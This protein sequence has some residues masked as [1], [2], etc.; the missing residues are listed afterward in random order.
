MRE[1]SGVKR[2]AWMDRARFFAILMVVLCH[3]VEFGYAFDPWFFRNYFDLSTW[4]ERFLF[5]TMGRLGVPLLLF[6][7]G[8]LM[9]NRDYTTDD[10]IRAFYKKNYLRIFICVECWIVL[11]GFYLSWRNALPFDWRGTLL[12]L[13]ALKQVPLGH[14]WYTPML[15]GL[16]LLLPF[17]ARAVRGVSLR[18]LGA[19]CLV[20]FFCFSAMPTVSLAREI[21][22]RSGYESLLDLGFSGGL[23]GLYVLLGYIAA[24]RKALRR[25]PNF[26]LWI[27]FLSC[28]ALTM[29]FQY[30]S[31]ACGQ[32]YKVW[33]DFSGILIGAL[34]LFELFRRSGARDC[35]H[36]DRIAAYFS[37]RSFAIYFLHFPIMDALHEL[38]VQRWLGPS[39][40]QTLFFW[41][42]SL[43]GSLF[44]CWVLEH[45]KLIRKYLLYIS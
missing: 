20:S 17:A 34:L 16:Y 23:Y 21:S 5:L 14:M 7:T 45:V 19:V 4:I 2:I 36:L 38:G 41:C 18:T 40:W 39:R 9:L 24:Q 30:W 11:Y 31:Y 37:R 43:A 1:E 27:G 42:A 22:G 44:L 26:A 35:P 3:A 33:Y 15:L 10:Q 29:A 8:T 32:P 28:V 6:L 13:A 12:A 25:I